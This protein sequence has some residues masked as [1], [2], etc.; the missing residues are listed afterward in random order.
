[1][2]TGTPTFTIPANTTGYKVNANC[3]VNGDWQVI[4]VAPHMHQLGTAVHLDGDGVVGE[5]SAS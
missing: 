3:T 4:G 1:M 2:W 5:H